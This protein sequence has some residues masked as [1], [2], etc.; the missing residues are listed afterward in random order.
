MGEAMR[1][2]IGGPSKFYAVILGALCLAAQI[3][4]PY[5]P[6]APESNIG[7]RTFPKLAASPR[8]VTAPTRAL[9]IW[10]ATMN[11]VVRNIVQHSMKP[12]SAPFCEYVAIPLG[13]SSAAPVNRPGPS[14]RDILAPAYKEV[15]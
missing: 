4:V 12:S 13:S 5:R 8:P 11:G 14:T 6:Y 1:L 2:L 15:F 9:T 10:I 3:F 7:G